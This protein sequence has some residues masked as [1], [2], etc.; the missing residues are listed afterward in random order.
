MAGVV[1]DLAATV[2][3]LRGVEPYAT[4]I[5]QLLEQGEK[6]A[7]TPVEAAWICEYL[8]PSDQSLYDGLFQALEFLPITA[9]IGKKAGS[10]MSAYPDPEILGLECALTA[11]SAFIYDMSLWTVPDCRKYYPMNDIR[12]FEP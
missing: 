10:Y 11:A 6:V 5:P 7:W 1:V 8:S 4:L 3:W 2:Q 12:F 9:E